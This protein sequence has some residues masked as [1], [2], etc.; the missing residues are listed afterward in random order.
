M[1]F[2]EAFVDCFQ[3]FVADVGGDVDTVRWVK[4]NS[5]SVS[6]TLLTR[7]LWVEIKFVVVS[8]VLSASWYGGVEE[9]ND[10]LLDE[11]LDSRL[12]MDLGIPQST[13][14]W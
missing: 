3:K 4:P 5:V 1:V 7:W 12:L 13:D 10:C 2:R 14:A 8:T 9:S 11:M 6:W